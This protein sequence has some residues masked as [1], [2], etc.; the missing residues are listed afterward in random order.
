ME[1]KKK[2]LIMRKKF[3]LLPIVFNMGLLPLIVKLHIFDTNLA[4]FPWYTAIGEGADLFNYYKKVFFLISTGCMVL[5]LIWKLVE[6]KNWKIFGTRRVFLPLMGYGLFVFLSAVFS[7][8]E[9]FVIHGVNGHFETLFVLLGYCITVVYSF[10]FIRDETDVKFVMVGWGIC[11]VPMVLLGLSQI[12]GHDFFSTQIGKALYLTRET[13]GQGEEINFVFGKGRV[14][15]SLYNPNYVGAFCMLAFPMLLVMGIWERKRLKQAF[16]LVLAGGILICII[17]A[18]AKTAFTVMVLVLVLLLLFL[19]KDVV[20]GKKGFIATAVI[21]TAVIAGANYYFDGSFFQILKNSFLSSRNSSQYTLEELATEQN[22]VRVVYKGEILYIHSVMNEQGMMGFVVKDGDGQ[23]LPGQAA[24]DQESGMRFEIDDDRFSG[25]S[26]I[27]IDV[28]S[29]PCFSVNIEGRDWVFSNYTGYEGC[30]YYSPYGK[31]MKMATAPSIGFEGYER[32]FSSRG[33]IW[34]RTLPLL[35]KHLFLGSGPDTFLFEFP[36]NDVL[37]RERFFENQ[38]I[39]KPHNI[40]LQIAV[41]TGCVSLLC[42]ALFYLFYFIDCIR[43]YWK[44]GSDSVLSRIG[45]ALCAAT[46]GYMLI[47]ITT[48]SSITVAPLFW[49]MMGIGLAVNKIIRQKA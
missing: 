5:V 46:A 48:D 8:Y 49:S 42:F 10:Y 40:Y 31:F 11:L 3:Y 35:K 9:W 33:Y 41:Q 38:L 18:I 17:G 7:E 1:Y 13:R 23:L 34:S 45:T 12:S 2:T 14:Y 39:S 30:Y 47:G 26:L 27:P 44:H 24:G 15:L 32:I 36:Q 22:E 25:I 16:Y 28:N 4:Q 19:R 21:L 20:A 37:S 6:E 29:I 43:L